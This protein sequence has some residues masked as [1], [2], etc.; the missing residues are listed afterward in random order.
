[1]SNRQAGAIK[2]WTWGDLI[3]AREQEEGGLELVKIIEHAE[4][5]RKF[6]LLGGKPKLTNDGYLGKIMA[7]GGFWQQHMGG[8]LTIFYPPGKTEK[9][10]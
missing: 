5:T 1:M 2:P 3:K 7:D 8:C 6:Y 4:H 10:Y 9:N